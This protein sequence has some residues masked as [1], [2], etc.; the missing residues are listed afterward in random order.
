MA[1]LPR[2]GFRNPRGSAFEMA[3]ENSQQRIG[4]I[5][6][7]VERVEVVKNVQDA[8]GKTSRVFR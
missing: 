3:E 1:E 2:T 8:D 4:R 7:N 6:M 5:R